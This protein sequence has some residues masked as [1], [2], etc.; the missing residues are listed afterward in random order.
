MTSR[1]PPR[2]IDNLGRCIGFP[3]AGTPTLTLRPDRDQGACMT[4]QM[5]EP[6]GYDV[7]GSDK[8]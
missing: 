4:L 8:A 2:T 5:S 7:L 6:S 1:A 3:N